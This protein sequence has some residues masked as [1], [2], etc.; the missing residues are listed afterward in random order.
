MNST[1][2]GVPTIFIIAILAI[3]ILFVWKAKPREQK[4]P[5]VDLKKEVKKDLESYELTPLKKPLRA[6]FQ[7]IGYAIGYA[8]LFYD[9]TLPL[10][11]NIK[12]NKQA[13]EATNTTKDVETHYLIKYCKNN[14]IAK[15]MAKLGL[16]GK[17]MILPT[18]AVSNLFNEVNI[19]PYSQP[20]YFL[21]IAVYGR[22][23]KNFIENIAFKLNRQAELEELAGWIPKMNYLETNIAGAVAKAREKAQIEKE[24]YKGQ[25]ESAEE[26]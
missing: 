9:K 8:N 20:T 5:H 7:N 11:A 22:N 23:A 15:S 16:A 10:A 26:V 12:R 4:A 13:K 24:K 18:E 25:I 19:E 17:F 1:F 2:L 14:F 3:V 21:D 6:G